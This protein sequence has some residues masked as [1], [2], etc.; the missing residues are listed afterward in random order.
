MLVWRY[1]NES[2][3]FCIAFNSIASSLGVALWVLKFQKINQLLQ[4]CKISYLLTLLWSSID[5]AISNIWAKKVCVSYE[6]ILA[7]AIFYKK[8]SIVIVL[9]RYL[10]SY[11]NKYEPTI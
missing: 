8:L 11:Q 9:F 3:E 6:V 1:F 5:G 10:S 2:A 7:V 4:D